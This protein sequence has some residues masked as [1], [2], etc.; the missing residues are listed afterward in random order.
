M[1]PRIAVR[2]E[3]PYPDARRSFPNAPGLDKEP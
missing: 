2:Q 1:E 3:C